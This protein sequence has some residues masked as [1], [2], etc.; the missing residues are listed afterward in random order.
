ME[1]RRIARRW[2]TAQGRNPK[3]PGT[4]RHLGIPGTCFQDNLFG[5]EFL[6]GNVVCYIFLWQIFDSRCHSSFVFE[7]QAVL[8]GTSRLPLRVDPCRQTVWI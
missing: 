5:L 2:A 6:S 7:W 1:R 3:F 8:T 4:H